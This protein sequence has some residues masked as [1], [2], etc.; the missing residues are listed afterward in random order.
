MFESLMVYL[1]SKSLK[2][3]VI[4]YVLSLAFLLVLS[5]KFD[6]LLQQKFNYFFHDEK[7]S[8][9][10]D[11]KSIDL[12]AKLKTFM[13]TILQDVILLNNCKESFC[14][15]KKIDLSPTLSIQTYEL[16]YEGSLQDAMEALRKL[17][18]L[19]FVYISHLTTKKDGDMIKVSLRFILL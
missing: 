13:P 11:T 6:S 1:R 19:N 15:A 5:S 12:E 10:S 18:N 3:L 9:K 17:E 7:I 2:E 14:S 4:F 16:N 8:L